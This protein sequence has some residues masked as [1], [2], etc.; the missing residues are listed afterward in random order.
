L[1][2]SRLWFGAALAFA[3]FL[4]IT[5]GHE[6]GPDHAILLWVDSIRMPGLTSAAVIVTALGS[7]AMIAIVSALALIIRLTLRDRTGALQIPAASAGAW[8]LMS[9]VKNLVHRPRPSVIP[10][11][12]EVT[13]FSYPSGHALLTAALYLTLGLIAGRRAIF[14]ILAAVVVIVGATR[15]YLG[16]HYPS[17]VASGFALGAAW[18]LFLAGLFNPR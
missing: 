14:V 11:L 4:A 6:D 17:D 2:R 8:I 16:V 1:K 15:V 13:G 5:A 10:K 3:V 9:V 7:N 18:A 12:V